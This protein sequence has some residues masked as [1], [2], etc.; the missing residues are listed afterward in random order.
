MGIRI[1]FLSFNLTDVKG[2]KNRLVDREIKPSKTVNLGY[3]GFLALN[4]ISLS[5]LAPYTEPAAQKMSELFK[6]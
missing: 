4:I 2:R 6:N 5:L 1:F 3:L